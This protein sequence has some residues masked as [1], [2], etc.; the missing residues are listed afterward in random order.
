MDINFTY[1]NCTMHE[2]GVSHN[3]I[4]DIPRNTHKKKSIIH[5]TLCNIAV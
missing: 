3:I 1:K 5:Y 2:H 4:N